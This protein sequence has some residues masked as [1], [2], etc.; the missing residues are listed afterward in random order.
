MEKVSFVC[1][2]KLWRACEIHSQWVFF[3]SPRLLQLAL[4]HF[5]VFQMLLRISLVF[6][7]FLVSPTAKIRLD[8]ST[9]SPSLV[10]CELWWA[11][12]KLCI[13]DK[14]TKHS[15]QVKLSKSELLADH[16]TTATQA[17]SSVEGI[18]NITK[19]IMVQS[20]GNSPYSLNGPRNIR[21]FSI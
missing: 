21:L 12:T 1:T 5:I 15:W 19:F 20:L 11:F 7:V 6:P 9:S 4:S 18:A 8:F 10:F 13:F 2:K 3:A 16:M 17:P 14:R